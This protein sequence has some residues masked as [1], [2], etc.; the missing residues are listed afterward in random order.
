MWKQI[1]INCCA[2]SVQLFF[3]AK[4]RPWSVASIILCRVELVLKNIFIYCCLFS[5]WTS[6]LALQSWTDF[7]KHIYLLLSFPCVDT[8]FSFGAWPWSVAT[9]VLPKVRTDVKH[10]LTSY[11]SNIKD[12]KLIVRNCYYISL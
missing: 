4:A 12:M 6:F 11:P 1:L 3:F 8:F 7:E 2:L 5:V 9:I 10:K